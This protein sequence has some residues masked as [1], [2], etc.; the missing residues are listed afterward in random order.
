M[1]YFIFLESFARRLLLGTVLIILFIIIALHFGL[2]DVGQWA[3]DDFSIVNS[4]RDDSW[5]TFGDRLMHWS[6]RPLSELLI[7]AYACL[8]NW[9]HKPLIG[10]FLGL[11][12]LPLILAP[13]ISFI[14]IRNNFSGG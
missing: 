13:V 1:R 7:W 9:T 3:N 5:A 6:P 4:Y 10:V 11:L 8:V 14:Q 12:W 2:V